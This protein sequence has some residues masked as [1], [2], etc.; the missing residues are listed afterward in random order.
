MKSTPRELVEH[1]EASVSLPRGDGERFSGYGVMGLPFRSGHVL[2]LRRFVSSSIGPGYTS[3][4]HRAPS[5]DWIFYS[6]VPVRQA[7]ARFFGS[8]ATDAIQ[9]RIEL[10]WTSTDRLRIAMRDLDFEW[11]V[12]MAPSTATRIMNATGGLLPDA[13]WRNPGVLAMMERVAGPLLGV[14]HVGL[15]GRAPNGQRFIANPRTL[16]S[17]VDSRARLAGEDLGTP[18]PVSPQ[19]RLGDFWIPQRGIFALGQSTFETFDPAR[20]LSLTSRRQ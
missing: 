20:H 9:T 17:I 2:A 15:K 10:E 4:W 7:C 13:A 8:A 5:G 6:D 19:A 18:G 11:D 16:W 14:G 12:A 1:V 3:V